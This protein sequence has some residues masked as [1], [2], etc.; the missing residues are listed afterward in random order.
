MGA[1]QHVVIKQSFTSGP[2]L[3]EERNDFFVTRASECFGRLSSVLPG[4]AY[5][6]FALMR[7]TCMPQRDKRRGGSR[8][9]A[10]SLET[11]DC[12][13]CRR[14]KAP[15]QGGRLCTVGPRV[16]CLNALLQDCRAVVHLFSDCSQ[17][18]QGYLGPL[19]RCYSHCH[20]RNLPGILDDCAPIYVTTVANKP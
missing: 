8:I 5:T 14:G 18:E 6:P 13:R 11:P 15:V 3:C 7:I 20:I 1:V 9:W 10:A 4:S 17:C 16:D 12:V 2:S 19:R